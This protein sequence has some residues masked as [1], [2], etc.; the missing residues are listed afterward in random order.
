VISILNPRK[1]PTPPYSYIP[2]RILDTFGKIFE[3]I[4]L[5]RALREVD[6]HGLLR[7]EQLRFRHKQHGAAAG[8]PC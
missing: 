4:L 7:D 5:T 2:M 8:P 1:D 3:K 6:G